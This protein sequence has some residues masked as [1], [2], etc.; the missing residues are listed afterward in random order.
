M[1]LAVPVECRKR[2]CGE[3]SMEGR[4][5]GSVVEEIVARIH[6]YRPRSGPLVWGTGSW[7][8]RRRSGGS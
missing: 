6:S 7:A 8:G 4:D 3:V 5:W 1:G 2:E